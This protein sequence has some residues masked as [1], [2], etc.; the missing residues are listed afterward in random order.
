M[1]SSRIENVVVENRGDPAWS[2]S[3]FEVAVV[4]FPMVQSSVVD[5]YPLIM[6]C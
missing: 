3:S 6:V 1:V 2:Y 4:L 5:P